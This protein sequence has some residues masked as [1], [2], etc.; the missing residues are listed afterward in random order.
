MLHPAIT[1]AKLLYLTVTA[2]DLGARGSRLSFGPVPW[3]C[4]VKQ[5]AGFGGSILRSRRGDFP[6]YFKTNCSTE[7][8]SRDVFGAHRSEKG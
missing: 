6:K 5:L 3:P 4:P 2:L 7:D 1:Q 8:P